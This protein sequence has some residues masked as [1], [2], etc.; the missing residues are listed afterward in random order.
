MRI[1]PRNAEGTL[2]N[3]VGDFLHRA[4]HSRNCGIAADR[5]TSGLGIHPLRAIVR[6]L[7]I[8]P[9]R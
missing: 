3:G 8:V 1:V 2:D 7:Q 9:W 6:R 5:E 4:A